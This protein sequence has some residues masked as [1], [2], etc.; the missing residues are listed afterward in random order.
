MMP[1]NMARG[2][3]YVYKRIETVVLL[4]LVTFCSVTVFDSD[5]TIVKVAI[6]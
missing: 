4:I 2:T 5:V 6:V 1:Q 3:I